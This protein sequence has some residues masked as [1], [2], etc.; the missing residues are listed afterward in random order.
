MAAFLYRMAGEP[1]TVAPQTSPFTDCPRG[2]KFYKEVTWLESTGITTG[3]DNGT[4]RPDEPV[5]R[6]AMAA[7]LHRYDA[8]F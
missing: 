8:K 5:N 6:D 2:S 7:F 1:A 3:Y 4:Y